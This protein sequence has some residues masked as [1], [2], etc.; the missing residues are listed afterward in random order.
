MNERKSTNFL[1]IHDFNTFIYDHILQRGRKHSSRFGLP[2]FRTEE[3]L[4]GHIRDGFKTNHNQTTKM[5][6][7]GEHVKFKTSG[8]KIKSLP[9]I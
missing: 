9:L 2:A 3:K 5:P 4:H 7:K 1:Y 6:Q 8:R